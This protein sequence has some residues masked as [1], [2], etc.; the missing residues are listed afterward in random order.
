MFVYLL[1]PETRGRG[2]EDIDQFFVRSGN[3]LQVVKVAKDLP[4]DAG[5]S[6]VIEEKVNKAEHL[7][8]AGSM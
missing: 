2:L 3:A 6:T 4:W 8:E 7:E 1:C 5:M